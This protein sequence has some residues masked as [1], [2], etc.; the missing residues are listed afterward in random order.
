MYVGI[1][2]LESRESVVGIIISYGLEDRGVGVRA[3]VLSRIF[4]SLHRSDRPWGSTQPPIQ[5][6]P[7]ALS[8]G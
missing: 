6:V 7:G 8:P 3:P 2:Q 1:I 5:W 4:F